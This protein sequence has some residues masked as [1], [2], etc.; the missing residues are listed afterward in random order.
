MING[1]DNIYYFVTDMKKAVEFYRDILGLSV[2]DQDD[3]WASIS[4]NGARLGLHKANSGEFSKSSEKRAGATV[5]LNVSDI[6][7]AYA[8][9]KSKGVRFLGAVS[10]NPWGSHVSFSDPDGN[11]LDIREAPKAK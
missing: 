1:L 4:L 10:K 8:H 11:L 5:T 9:Y 2:I 3:H 6:D 7:Q